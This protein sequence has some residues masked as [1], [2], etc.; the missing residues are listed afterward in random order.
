[1][2]TANPDDADVTCKNPDCPKGIFE[3]KSILK[4]ISHAKQCKKFYTQAD[5]ESIRE[6]SRNGKNQREDA[7]QNDESLYSGKSGNSIIKSNFLQL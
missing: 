3:W 7:Q 6:N 2:A 4:H 5:I 1:M